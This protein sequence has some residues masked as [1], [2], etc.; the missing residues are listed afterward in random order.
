MQHFRDEF[1]QIADNILQCNQLSTDDKNAFFA[2]FDG[3]SHA[4]KK[5]LKEHAERYFNSRKLKGSNFEHRASLRCLG[6]LHLWS[7]LAS[8]LDLLE[9][10]EDIPLDLRDVRDSVSVG[11]W[12]KL[13]EML[14]CLEGVT[15]RYVV[16]GFYNNDDLPFSGI[17]LKMLPCRLALESIDI[18]D[19]FPFEVTV[20]T[21]EPVHEAT[22]FDAG[23]FD[24]W[25]PGGWTTPLASCSSEAPLREAVMPGEGLDGGWVQFDYATTPTT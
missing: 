9:F 11:N 5:A 8:D 18:E 4:S 23:L 22:A 17:D 12:D 25:R 21:D 2:E 10:L 15:L 14:E 16:W 13:E 1:P 24:L 20:P 19:Y 3:A 7:A 6:H